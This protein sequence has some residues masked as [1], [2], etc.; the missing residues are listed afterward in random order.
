MEPD[1]SIRNR[2]ALGLFLL[3]SA[4]YDMLPPFATGGTTSLKLRRR[5]DVVRHRLAREALSGRYRRACVSLEEDAWRSACAKGPS[6]RGPDA[7]ATPCRV[8]AGPETW[9]AVDIGAL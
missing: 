7:L 1:I 3:I 2:N 4:S 6:S 8:G 9:P 5:R